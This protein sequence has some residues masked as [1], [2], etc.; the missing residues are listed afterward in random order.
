MKAYRDRIR[1]IEEEAAC[2]TCGFP[3]YVGDPCVRSADDRPFCSPQC[4]RQDAEL[5]AARQRTVSA[6]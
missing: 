6:A 1:S 2:G 3:L 5:L 4:E